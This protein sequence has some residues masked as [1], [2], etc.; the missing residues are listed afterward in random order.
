MVTDKHIE[1]VKIRRKGSDSCRKET[2]TAEELRS[3]KGTMTVKEER[4]DVGT[5]TV[6]D[7]VSDERMVTVEES[8]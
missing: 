5:V 7:V 3:D 8:V 2:V 4:L 6:E 1:E